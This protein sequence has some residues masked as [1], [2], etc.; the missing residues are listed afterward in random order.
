MYTVPNPLPPISFTLNSQLIFAIVDVVIAYRQHT[1]VCTQIWILHDNENVI[2]A[3][4]TQQ[5]Y[6]EKSH[7]HHHHRQRSGV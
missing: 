6:F 1:Y 5:R 2:A 7:Q 3:L 4:R